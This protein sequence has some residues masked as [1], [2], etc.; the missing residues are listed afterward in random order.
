MSPNAGVSVQQK[1]FMSTVCNIQGSLYSGN[2]GTNNKRSPRNWYRRNLQ[3]SISLHFFY[4]RTNDFDGLSCGLLAIL[5]YPGALLS[6][7]RHF[8]KKRIK[9]ALCSGAPKCE[10]VH[11]RTARCYNQTLQSVFGNS[12]NNHLLARSGADIRII[13]CENNTRLLGYLRRNTLD[14]YCLG[15]IDAAMTNENAYPGYFL[16]A[17]RNHLADIISTLGR[18]RR[19]FRFSFRIRTHLFPF[20]ARSF[21]QLTNDRPIPSLLCSK[22][23]DR[24][25]SCVK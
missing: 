16:P 11:L 13:R 20:P 14:I 6:D 3:L 5:V 12:I 15:N 4:D 18:L 9:A 7:V 22:P 23:N 25:S 17:A 1:H 19:R 8:A 2:T 21:S 10:F 24:P